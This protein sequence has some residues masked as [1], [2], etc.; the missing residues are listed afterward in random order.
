MAEP[1]PEAVAAFRRRVLGLGVIWPLDEPY[2][3]LLRRLDR[4]R[5]GDLAA[6]HAAVSLFRGAGYVPFEGAPPAQPHHAALAAPYTHVTAPLRRL[7]DRFSL[8]IAHAVANSVPVPGWAKEGLPSLPEAMKAS[9][10][11]ASQLDRACLD[12]VEAAVLSQRVGQIFDAVVVSE[13]MV[14]IADPPVLA[15]CLG[16]PKVGAA[17][18]VTLTDADPAS[19]RVRFAWAGE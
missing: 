1:D 12:V 8:V 16:Q 15:K 3:E 9:D 17:V 13:N 18:R 11:L 6:L 5:P 4:S 2:G 7:V 10:H 14:Q 19:G